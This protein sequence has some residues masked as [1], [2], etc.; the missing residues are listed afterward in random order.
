M[1]I[2]FTLILD[3]AE[4]LSKK[5][6][7]NGSSIY[8]IHYEDCEGNCKCCF[9]SC[10][11]K[12]I[13]SVNKRLDEWV[14]EERM[15]MS[16]IEQPQKDTKSNTPLKL[17]NGAH[18]RTDSRPPSPEKECHLVNIDRRSGPHIDSCRRKWWWRAESV[19]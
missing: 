8:Y 12:K 19:S 1:I 9:I 16:R 5:D 14:T 7:P 11:N 10:F 2:T 13:F 4:I 6:N 3:W 17:T 15:D 18:H